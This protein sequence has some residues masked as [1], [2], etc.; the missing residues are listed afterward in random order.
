MSTAGNV[1]IMGV[2]AARASGLLR[3]GCSQRRVST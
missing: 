2:G 1:L 3:G